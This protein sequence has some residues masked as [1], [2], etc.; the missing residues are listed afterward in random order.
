MAEGLMALWPIYIHTWVSGESDLDSR[1]IECEHHD[2]GHLFWK[3]TIQK[4]KFKIG[5]G[6]RDVVKTRV[7]NTM[8]HMLHF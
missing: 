2:D 1:C 7:Q 3:S 4:K 5:S 6:L 8:L